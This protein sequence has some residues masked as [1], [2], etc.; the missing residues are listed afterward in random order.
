MCQFQLIAHSL[1]SIVNWTVHL[2]IVNRLQLPA[3]MFP[4]HE[5]MSIGKRGAVV[6]MEL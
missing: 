3:E 6:E 2:L 1:V 5:T 4:M